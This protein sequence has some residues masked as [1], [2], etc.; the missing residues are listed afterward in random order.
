M[1]GFGVAM[2]LSSAGWQV[3]AS[4]RESRAALRDFVGIY[5][6]LDP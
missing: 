1:I 2:L 4:D 5:F 3:P 6:S